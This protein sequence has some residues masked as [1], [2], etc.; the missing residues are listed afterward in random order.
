MKHQPVKQD[1]TTTPGTSCPTLFVKCVGSLTSPAIKPCNTEDAGDW[2]YGLLSSSEKTWVSNHLHMQLQRE[3]ILLSYCRVSSSMVFQK[4]RKIGN[5]LLKNRNFLS[6]IRKI[7]TTLM[8]KDSLSTPLLS[9]STALVQQHWHKCTYSWQR[10]HLDFKII[11]L[12]SHC[13]NNL[14]LFNIGV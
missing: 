4:N 1:Q 14:S 3:Y 13:D 8:D 12:S 6:K 5:T 9:Q 7:S 11:L 10:R 2:A